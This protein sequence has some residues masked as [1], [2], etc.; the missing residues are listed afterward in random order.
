MITKFH[1]IAKI[2]LNILGTYS[3]ISCLNI[4]MHFTYFNDTL[5]SHEALYFW[6][7][8]Y[9]IIVLICL[10]CLVILKY[11]YLND[12][13]II[14]IVGL[15]KDDEKPVSELSILAG[16]RFSY[17]FCGM[18]IIV[19][20]LNFIIESLFFLVNGPRILAEMAIHKYIHEMFKMPFESYFNI[21]ITLF[22]ILFG[23]YLVLGAKKFVNW[24]V[25]RLKRSFTDINENF[26]LS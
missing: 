16:L 23:F 11:F 10:I 1:L 14:K 18:M 17:V 7:E 8:E 4:L 5:S 21:V 22:K 12:K 13:W 3:F 24:Q 25:K 6:I 26:V 20:N 9:A 15:T 19:F 2:V